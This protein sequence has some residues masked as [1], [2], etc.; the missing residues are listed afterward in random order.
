MSRTQ[1]QRRC[2]ALHQ[3]RTPSVQT[4][5]QQS[6]G[7]GKV[8]NPAISA[9]M[10]E[11]APRSDLDVLAVSQCLLR[12]GK[13]YTYLGVLSWAKRKEEKIKKIA[14]VPPPPGRLSSGST[15][16]HMLTHRALLGI[17]IRNEISIEEGD[18]QLKWRLVW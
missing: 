5:T 8:P 3:I 1:R 14:E 10:E 9:G 18:L 7:F 11:S 4:R 16:Q 13:G 17:S 6:A 12:R 15:Q 2:D